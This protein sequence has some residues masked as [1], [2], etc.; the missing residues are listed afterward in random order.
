MITKY[1][2][3]QIQQFVKDGICPLQTLRDYDVVMAAMSGKKVDDIAFDNRVS[4]A[5]VYN[6]KKK[7]TPQNGKSV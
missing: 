4:R 7:Y 6:I 1:R 2:R 3:E 5:Q